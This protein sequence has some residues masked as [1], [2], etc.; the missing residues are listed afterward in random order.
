LEAFDPARE[1]GAVAPDPLYSSA[2]RRQL[3]VMFVDLVGSTELS[4]RLDPE[5]LREVLRTYHALVAEVVK[6]HDGHVAQYLG[7]GALVYFGY[8]TSQEDDAERSIKAA[9]A[10][11]ARTSALTIHGADIR[12]RVG[13]ATGLVVVGD[14]AIGSDAA[15]EPRVMGET[16]NIAARLQAMARPQDILIAE[17][18]RQLVGRLFAY[19]ALGPI[20]LKG[21]SRPV[22]A[23]NVIAATGMEDRFAALR[24]EA[25]PFV[26]REEELE[27]LLRRWRQIPEE[28]GKAVLVSG[29]PGIGKSRLLAVARDRIAADGPQIVTYFALRTSPTRRFTQ[30]FGR[31]DAAAS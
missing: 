14:K 1:I 20:E 3:T 11:V 25:A 6:D 8:P 27:F 21:V 19:E 16:P 26:G 31:L 10:L 17:S 2:E 30:S 5:D 23:W 7:D 13:I 9:L 18:T 24:S 12:I 15:H 4:T 28:G 29:E 22:A